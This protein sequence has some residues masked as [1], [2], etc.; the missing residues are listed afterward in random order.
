MNQG[1]CRTDVGPPMP[2]SLSS[3]SSAS[4]RDCLD[5]VWYGTDGAMGTRSY[6][7]HDGTSSGFLALW[8]NESLCDVELCTSDGTCIPAHK[9][10]L[11]AHSPFFQAMFA[12]ASS[13]M[14]ENVKSLVSVENVDDMTLKKLLRIIYGNI[15]SASSK[16]ME[17]LCQHLERTVFQNQDG[18]YNVSV[19]RLLHAATYLMMHSVVDLCCK[20]LE[21]R[22][23]LSNV[24]DILILAQEHDCDDLYVTG[25]CFVVNHFGALLRF[26]EGAESIYLLPINIMID[27]LDD[28]VRER[29]GLFVGV[30]IVVFL[31]LWARH[32]NGSGDAE[33]LIRDWSHRQKKTFYHDEY[34]MAL[35]ALYELEGKKASRCN[36]MPSDDALAFVQR[37]CFHVQKD[38]SCISRVPLKVTCASTWPVDNST[39]SIVV[40]G[41]ICNGWKPIRS[42]EVYSPR[43]DTWTF[44]PEMPS[45]CSFTHACTCSD[46]NTYIPS[47]KGNTMMQYSNRDMSWH[48]LDLHGE[49]TTRV[50]SACVAYGS[51][52]HILGGRP[53]V[54]RERHPVGLHECFKS[55]TCT[56]QTLSPMNIPRASLDACVIFDRIWCVG[57]Q[58]LR[59]THDTME[60]YEPALDSWYLSRSKLS[61]PRK[62]ATVNAFGE[63]L[64]QF[65]IVGG[66]DD[67]R[68]RLQSVEAYDP[69][70]GRLRMM[71][72]LPRP[73]SSA[74]SCVSEYNLYV[75]GGRIDSG[76]ET[77]RMYV[78][79]AR[80]PGTWR[81]CSSMLQPRSSLASWCTK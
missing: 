48:V 49:S 37:C 80:M 75:I 3:M 34:L 22:M 27:C 11:A 76:T 20:Y 14:I 71:S 8:E 9:V 52:V 70:E 81:E 1:G 57:G 29:N 31:L 23:N 60:W 39:C 12:G 58:S 54:G 59:Q 47:S 7:D 55:S 43:T 10:V 42:T 40:A 32:D 74:T 16:E 62:Y 73:I 21:H 50:S 17:G 2:M 13:N 19:S 64:S 61:T 65:V 63:S 53:T 69:R 18:A 44:G 38:V 4:S 30:D 56:W 45:D 68:T 51:S 67:K 41:G 79:D 33:E 66:M 35:E 77:D 24:V 78:L 5:D 6:H 26:P 72:S 28:I 36:I 46:G 25:K 15:A